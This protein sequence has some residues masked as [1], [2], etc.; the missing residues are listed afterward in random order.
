LG[1]LLIGKYRE[2]RVK[3][4]WGKGILTEEIYGEIEEK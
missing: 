2:R 3:Q 4:I 1:C